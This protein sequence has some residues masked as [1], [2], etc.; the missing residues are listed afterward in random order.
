MDTGEMEAIKRQ[1][2]QNYSISDEQQH[3]VRNL[4]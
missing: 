1:I 2:A 4:S 3:Q